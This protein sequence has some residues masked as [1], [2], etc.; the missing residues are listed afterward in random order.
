M[1]PGER[2]PVDLSHLEPF[3]DWRAIYPEL[4]IL[5]E[6]AA[7]VRAEVLAIRDGPGW[8]PWVQS[9]LYDADTEWTIFPFY[10]F[11]KLLVENAARVPRTRELLA[12]VPGVKTAIFSHLGP[13]ARINPHEGPP[14]LSNFTL[15][16]HLGLIVP[17]G[18]GIGCA[19]QVRPIVEGKLLMFDDILEHH[20]FNPGPDHRYVLIFD[21]ARP[22]PRPLDLPLPVWGENLPVWPRGWEA[23][24]AH[25]TFVPA[26][27]IRAGLEAAGL[28]ATPRS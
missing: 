4:A 15:R 5:E 22:E 18:C 24:G 9:H 14:A 20:G 1:T 25:G 7:A 28:I 11:D 17:D 13:G 2:R 6:N 23:I 16:C 21:V 8:F 10:G 27:T 19:G 12:Q 26:P 3:P